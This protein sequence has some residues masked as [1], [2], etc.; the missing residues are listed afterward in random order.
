MKNLDLKIEGNELTIRIDL[1]KE[2]G[3]SKSERS[4]IVASSLG[5]VRL[6]D[7]DKHGYRAEKINLSVTKPVPSDHDE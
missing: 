1:T 3:L 5:N 7:E 4:I 2:F 6:Y